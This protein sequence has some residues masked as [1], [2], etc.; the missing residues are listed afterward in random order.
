[1]A[2]A[3]QG[4]VRQPRQGGGGARTP[5]DPPRERAL[6]RPSRPPAGA[7]R[8]RPQPEGPRRRAPPRRRRAVFLRVGAAIERAAG[9]AGA[10]ARTEAQPQ[11][12][13]VMRRVR[14]LGL[15]LLL[16]YAGCAADGGQ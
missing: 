5:R 11:G 3:A 13:G 12:A 15:V 7:L 14:I 10:R 1:S 9:A 16:A 4:L 2:A 6:P 8:P